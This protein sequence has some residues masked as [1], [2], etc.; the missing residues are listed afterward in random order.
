VLEY[1]S[2]AQRQ[3]RE[4]G[5]LHADVHEQCAYIITSS[6]GASLPH[7]GV[8]EHRQGQRGRVATVRLNEAPVPCRSVGASAPTVM[9]D[10]RFAQAW[11]AR[12]LS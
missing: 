3:A 4:L 9:R 8:R 2:V 10:L 6:D 12:D 11:L 1:E 7:D 5:V